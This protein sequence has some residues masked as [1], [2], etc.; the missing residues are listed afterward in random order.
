[1]YTYPLA[2]V[3]DHAAGGVFEYVIWLL[4]LE[5]AVVSDSGVQVACRVRA[6]A[7]YRELSTNFTLT[8]LS[9]TSALRSSHMTK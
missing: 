5:S 8:L 4:L 6:N 7:S 3:N 9:K 2:V 1:M